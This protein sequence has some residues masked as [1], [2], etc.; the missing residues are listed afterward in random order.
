MIDFSSFQ[1]GKRSA[2]FVGL[3]ILA[4]HHAQKSMAKQM[5]ADAGD[6][7]PELLRAAIAEADS[8][9]GVATD[10][11]IDSV[12]ALLLAQTEEQI[13]LILRDCGFSF[14]GPYRIG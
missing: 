6:V 5:G 3:G 11:E 13:S 10:E 1:K 14:G 9:K 4:G 7:D 2:L 8:V 12:V